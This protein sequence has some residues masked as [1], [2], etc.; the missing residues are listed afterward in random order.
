MKILRV[1]LFYHSV[2]CVYLFY[3]SVLFVCV[4]YHCVLCLCICAY[5]SQIILISVPKLFVIILAK[6]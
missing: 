4:F 2:L 5:V 6:V 1:Y 3:Y